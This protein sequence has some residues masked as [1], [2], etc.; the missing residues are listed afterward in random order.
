MQ[1]TL[2]MKI[3]ML[4]IDVFGIRSY[5]GVGTM[6]SYVAMSLP[7]TLNYYCTSQVSVF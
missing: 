6:A 3:F 7:S 2:F 4:S 5:V 1:K